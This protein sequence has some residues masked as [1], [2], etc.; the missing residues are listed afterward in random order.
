MLKYR[1]TFG[2]VIVIGPPLFNCF[3]RGINPDEPNTFPNL[4]IEKNF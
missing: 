2:S 1:I 3:E 4:T